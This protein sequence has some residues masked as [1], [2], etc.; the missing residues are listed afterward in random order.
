MQN[1]QIYSWWRDYR[2]HIITIMLISSIINYVDRVNISFATANITREFNLSYSQIGFLLAAWMW[3]YAAANLPSGWLIDK[4]GINKIFVW[5]IILWSIATICGGLAIN[6]PQLYLSRVLLG[7]AEAPFFVIGAKIIQMYFASNA[8]GLASGVLNLGPKAANSLAPPIIAALIIFTGWRGMFIILGGSGFII[9]GLWLAIYKKDDNY[10]SNNNLNSKVKKLNSN[11]KTT[12]PTNFSIW[13]LIN[14]KTTWWFNLGNIGSSYVFWL[15][16][17]W[18]PTYLMNERGLNL[19]TTGWVST[20]PFLAGMIAV[21]LGGYL[22]DMLIKKYN[23]DF[24]TARVRPAL[25][26]CLVAGIA[27]IP[28]NYIDNLTIVVILFTISTFAISIR[29]GVL[30]ALVSD[31]SPKSAVGTFGGIQNCASFIG[32]A[33]APTISGIILQSTGNY[34]IVFGISGIL[35]ILAAFCYA[36]IDHHITIEDID[37]CSK[38]NTK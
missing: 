38:H 2:W 8:R 5:S 26:G 37:I 21:P 30:W 23:F 29:A 7:I 9:A 19:K 13:K 6:Y 18:L 31:I 1:K 12:K 11:L 28:I 10:P 32:G 16:F 3:P 35:V 20:V 24:I 17:T 27:V 22:S 36:M 4:L 15:Y 33:L 34:N 25:I 14:H